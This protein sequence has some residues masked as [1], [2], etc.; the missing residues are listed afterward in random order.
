MTVIQVIPLILYHMYYTDRNH[1]NG[2]PDDDY[3]TIIGDI[4]YLL[5]VFCNFFVFIFS[6]SREYH[7]DKFAVEATKNP[8]ALASS[9][10]K[11][12]CGLTDYYNNTEDISEFEKLLKNSKSNL[13]SLAPSFGIFDVNT[14]KTLVVT[15]YDDGKFSMENIKKV[16]RWELWNPW[17]KLYE[18]KSS[19]PLFSKRINA[20]CKYCKKYGQE[21]F[22][23]FDERQPES[24]VDDFILELLI[25]LLPV[26][27]F[28][29]LLFI[30]IYFASSI[31]NFMLFI[32]I[33]IIIFAL[34]LLVPF[35]HTYRNRD[36]KEYSVKDLI[37]EVK[38]SG[39]T[40]IPCIVKGEIVARS[41][42]FFYFS[43]DFV[44]KDGM[45]IMYLDYGQSLW[46]TKSLFNLLKGKKYINQEVII[47]GWYRR[48]PVPYIEIY[49]LTTNDKSKK[50]YF[51]GFI[52][53]LLIFMMCV[54]AFIMALG[55][56]L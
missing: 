39:I 43:D 46:S 35:K 53:G 3:A 6:R 20:I 28:C 18:F 11:I 9:L 29:L 45:G 1:R 30:G 56:V 34:S 49:N 13:I 48:S 23:S 36:F 14:L 41:N 17:S 24:Y 4:T 21:E 26:I 44:I 52:L 37:G 40:S 47:K 7:A 33:S 15:S 50:C 10:V 54:G 8:N 38:V 16:A 32:G 42:L 2:S 31:N 22:V 27:T 55:F 12:G 51:Y 25:K 19:H 5:Y